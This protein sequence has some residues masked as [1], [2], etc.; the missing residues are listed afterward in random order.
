MTSEVGLSFAL[1]ITAIIISLTA[2]ALSA[3]FGLRQLRSMQRANSTMVTIELLTRECR[4]NEFLESEEFVLYELP[5][6]SPGNGVTGLT[7]LQR[8]HATRVGLFYSSLGVL[9]STGG[10]ETKMIVAIVPN[11]AR[12][13]WTAL[14]PYIRAERTLRS[15]TY[16]S[17]F[18]HLVCLINEAD[19]AR[20]H[21]IHRLRKLPEE[22]SVRNVP[23]AP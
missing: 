14:E 23:A 18:E 5:K 12:R 11:R 6:A 4:T 10:V 15:P 16:V 21:E 17:F 7:P 9:A 2:V 3:F 19:P 8:R 22:I 1:N 20:H 13:A